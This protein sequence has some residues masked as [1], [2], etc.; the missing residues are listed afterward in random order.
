MKKELPIIFIVALMALSMV[1]AQEIDEMLMSIQNNQAVEPAYDSGYIRESA[2]LLQTV[3]VGETKKSFTLGFPYSQEVDLKFALVAAK[4]CR[5][6]TNV[7]LTLFSPLKKVVDSRIIATFY[8]I[9]QG[10]RFTQRLRYQL[11]LAKLKN[12]PYGTY[13]LVVTAF[14]SGTD[15]DFFVAT[16][17]KTDDVVTMIVKE[18]K[19]I[20]EAPLVLQAQKEACEERQPYKPVCFLA[21]H[22][23]VQQQKPFWVVSQKKCFLKTV[24][25]D[26]CTLNEVCSQGKCIVPKKP[27]QTEKQQERQTKKQCAGQTKF[28][29]FKN[30]NK[31]ILIS[32]N[33]CVARESAKFD[34]APQESQQQKRLVPDP[35][36]EELIIGEPTTPVASSP[37]GSSSRSSSQA[38]QQEEEDQEKEE[39]CAFF[40]RLFQKEGCKLSPEE[41]TPV[42]VSVIF[43]VLIFFVMVIMM[44]R[45]RQ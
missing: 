36:E 19:P 8:S 38:Q 23:R 45:G 3:F 42:A 13:R 32:K 31:Y 29:D 34:C 35:T 18:R 37:R 20:I 1:S 26:R 41:E 43:A 24:I 27:E 40:S 44:M 10:Q 17:S 6:K 39:E 12:Q 11:P 15:G 5:G 16:P 7:D 2:G 28:C 25:L 14:C 22:D 9:T 30:N 21:D 33:I 4:S